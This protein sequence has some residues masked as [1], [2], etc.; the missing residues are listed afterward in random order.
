MIEKTYLNLS[1]NFL[2]GFLAGC[3]VS[4]EGEASYGFTIVLASMVT[5]AIRVSAL[6][7]RVAPVS[8]EMD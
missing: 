4:F 5:A 8:K 7:F 6:P 2:G 1:R 3:V